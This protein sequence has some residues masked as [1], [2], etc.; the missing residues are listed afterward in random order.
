M[1]PDEIIS[2]ARIWVA[3]PRRYS[4]VSCD[5]ETGY[6]LDCSGCVSMAWGVDGLG[7]GAARVDDESQKAGLPSGLCQGASSVVPLRGL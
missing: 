2:R 7:P 1:T 4:Q 6:R 5:P 3:A